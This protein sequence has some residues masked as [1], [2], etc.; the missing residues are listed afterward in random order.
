MSHDANGLN[1]VGAASDGL[2]EAHD[3]I[4]GHDGWFGV[5]GSQCKVSGGKGRRA[6]GLN[7][8]IVCD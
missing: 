4:D 6:K 5:N 7:A 1:E 3:E 8:K 2:E